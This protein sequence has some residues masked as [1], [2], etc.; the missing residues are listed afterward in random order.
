MGNNKKTGKKLDFKKFISGDLDIDD[1]SL[2]YVVRRIRREKCNEKKLAKFMNAKTQREVNA[3]M[4]KVGNPFSD[5]NSWYYALDCVCDDFN[6][7]VRTHLG[8]G[9]Q[10]KKQF[11]KL[12]LEDVTLQMAYETFSNTQ[13]RFQ[14][15]FILDKHLE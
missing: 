3:L 1:F 10:P 2:R 8:N 7:L 6:D 13:I 14:V 15:G 4:K 9:V 11:Q 5:T 12:Q